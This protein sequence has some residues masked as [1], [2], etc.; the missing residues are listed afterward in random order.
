MCSRLHRFNHTNVVRVGVVM[1]GL[2]A[3]RHGLGSIDSMANLTH[4][5][6]RDTPCSKELVIESWVSSCLVRDLVAN[7][8]TLSSIHCWP[9][10]CW[11]HSSHTSSSLE[12]PAAV[13]A[14]LQGLFWT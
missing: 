5:R 4:R 1:V 10:A 2:A 8:R 9:H 12:L 6:E 3:L 11:L 7:L 14:Q 13:L